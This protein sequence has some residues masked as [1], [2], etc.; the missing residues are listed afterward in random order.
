MVVAR[1]RKTMWSQSEVLACYPLLSPVCPSL[2][3]W[4]RTCSDGSCADPYDSY[5]VAVMLMPRGLGKF[6]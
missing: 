6:E 3:A 1:S 5:K 4:L 2:G